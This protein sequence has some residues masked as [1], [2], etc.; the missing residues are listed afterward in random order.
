MRHLRAGRPL[1]RMPSEVMAKIDARDCSKTRTPSR[2]YCQY[3]SV[4]TGRFPDSNSVGD[5]GEAETRGHPE[6]RRDHALSRLGN[7]KGLGLG[8]RVSPSRLFSVLIQTMDALIFVLYKYYQ[9]TDQEQELFSQCLPVSLSMII[10]QPYQDPD[11]AS[12]PVLRI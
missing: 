3:D 10:S 11:P 4:R 6:T 9:T 7:I 1:G 8:V 5:V 12:R 2:R